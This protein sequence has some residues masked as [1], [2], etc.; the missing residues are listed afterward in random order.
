MKKEIMDAIIAGTPKS[1][2]IDLSDVRMVDIAIEQTKKGCW[3]IEGLNASFR[4]MLEDCKPRIY[5]V[6]VNVE[7]TIA[8]VIHKGLELKERH[9]MPQMTRKMK[10]DYVMTQWENFIK[11]WYGI[12]RN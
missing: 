2:Y 5:N 7:G 12:G 8:F 4:D 10:R 11:N 9:T 1:E 3:R 6:Y